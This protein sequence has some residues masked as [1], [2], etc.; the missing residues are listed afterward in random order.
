VT[1]AGIGRDENTSPIGTTVHD[2]IGHPAEQRSRVSRVNL[3]SKI[4]DKATHRL[5]FQALQ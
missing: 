4:S 5:P 3:L 2:R 1:K